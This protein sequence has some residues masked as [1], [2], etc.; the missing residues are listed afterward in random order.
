[1]L[2]GRGM[3][4]SRHEGRMCILAFYGIEKQWR[5]MVALDSMTYLIESIPELRE[6]RVAYL[7]PSP[8]LHYRL[9]GSYIYDDPEYSHTMRDSQYKIGILQS[10]TIH[11]R[12]DHEER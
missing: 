6:K 3:V 9:D 1:M 4:A 8:I 11:R 10:V 12:R 5:Y 7:H 2:V